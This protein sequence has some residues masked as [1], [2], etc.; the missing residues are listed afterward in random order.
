MTAK[1]KA[2]ILPTGAALDKVCSAD[3]RAI[4]DEQFDAIWN[5]AEQPFTTEQ[6]AEVI[7]EAEV[8]LSSWGSPRITP[9]LLGKAERLRYFGHAAGSAKGFIP[10]DAITRGVKIFSGAPRLA[11]SVGEYC[12]AALLSMLRRLPQGSKAAKQGLWWEYEG[13]HSGHELTGNTIGIVSASATARAFLHLLTPFQMN[14]LV[15]DPYLSSEQ[16]QQLGVTRASLEEV[17]ACPIISIHAPSLP[18]TVNLIHDQLIRSIPDGAIL[19][20]SSRGAVLDE[21]ALLEELRSG[22]FYAAL[23]VLQ[24][25]PPGADSPFLTLDNVLVTPHIAGSTVQCFQDL[26]PQ[27][28]GAIL[29]SMRGERSRY[30]ID[31][32]AW[33]ILA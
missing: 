33:A 21:E 19:I 2:L 17:M 14:I 7:G 32:N 5:P 24:A 31:R 8:I 30:E 29:R 4:I 11:Q 9:E 15:Y 26:M 1:T 16:A 22:R 13:R 25:E 27:V 18:A 6:L 12:L 20:N 28:A 3:F 10:D 23:D